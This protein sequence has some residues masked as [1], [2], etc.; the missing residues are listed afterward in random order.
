MTG[1]RDPFS[2]A[3]PRE[4]PLP[5]AP[6]VR[7]L[8]QIRFPEI[9]AVE[10]KDFVAG[11]QEVLRGTY[12]VLRQEQVVTA[13]LAP[14]G[15]PQFKPENAWRFND[16]KSEWR[17]SLS[18]TFVSLETL[19][20]VSRTDFIDRLGFVLSALDAHVKPQLIDRIGVRY[21]DRLEG[22]A[23]QRMSEFL[24][25]S[26][27]GI[28]GTPLRDN[29]THSLSESLFHLDRGDLL[30]RWGSLPPEQT[31]DPAV[32]PPIPEKSWVLDLD[33]FSTSPMSFDVS[34][35]QD[36]VKAYAERIHAFF[37]WATTD[38]FLK[39]YG[40]QP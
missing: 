4:V 8:T 11:F 14:N 31:F 21:V 5:N 25:P 19:K 32:M 39:H 38:A 29:V 36:T 6:L 20:Y 23:Y 9:L 40:G 35:V 22:E 16:L 17:I 30:A 13:T 33:M 26:I 1:A 12:P 18:P 7:V 3:L 24:D 2:E 15:L 10:Q 28:L 37:R 27:L 34:Q